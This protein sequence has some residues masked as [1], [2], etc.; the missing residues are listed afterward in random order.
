MSVVHPASNNSGA[1]SA[2]PSSPATLSSTGSQSA[3]P[4]PSAGFWDIGAYKA[5]VQRIRDGSEQLEELTKL[6]KERIDIENKYGKSLQAWYSKWH[7]YSERQVPSGFIKSSLDGI[8]SESK[9]LARVHLAV[10]ERFNDEIVKT[11]GLF[12]KDNYHRSAIRGF[13]EAKETEEEFE[14]AQRQWKKLYEK[15]ETSKKQYYCCC[16]AEK[17]AYIQMMNSHADTTLS[18]DGADKARD[19]HKKCREEVEKARATYEQHLREITHFNNVYMESMAFVFEK[20]QQME[21][22]RMK[23]VVEMLSGMQKVLVDLLSPPK[24]AQIHRI[25]EESFAM[26]GDAQLNIDLK[27]WSQ[28]HGTDVPP[29]FPAY[30][31]YTPEFR[32]ISN[33]G[34]QNS[35]GDGGVVLTKKIYRSEDDM[36]RPNSVHGDL[37]S[38]AARG[39]KRLAS[40][41]VVSQSTQDVHSAAMSMNTV[42]VP[43]AKSSEQLAHRR[44]SSCDSGQD[45]TTTNSDPISN[46]TSINGEQM[47]NQSA[48][49]SNPTSNSAAVRHQ[50]HVENEDPL[51]DPFPMPTPQRSAREVE[52]SNGIHSN[53]PRTTQ[54]LSSSANKRRAES[55]L[56]ENRVQDT[57]SNAMIKSIDSYSPSRHSHLHNKHH[58]NLHTSKA[59]SQASTPLKF[60]QNGQER[61]NNH[62]DE[63]YA[64]MQLNEPQNEAITKVSRVEAL[65]DY[66][67]IESDEIPLTKGEIIL[68]LSEPDSLGWCYGQKLD[69]RIVG[70]F[71]ASYVQ[72][73]SK[74]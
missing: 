67:P 56:K 1:Q 4:S 33:T 57:D 53:Q 60:E 14:K 44:G 28:L 5:N 68:S 17:S 40:S 59:S 19:R 3:T 55:V 45:N 37:N 30:E 51:A 49:V 48:A 13:K 36:H 66:Q 7:I 26:L 27:K 38:N 63:N 16:R 50:S 23:F 58:S 6:V 9:E 15:V 35:K 8:L 65:Y 62:R 25:L 32:N 70:W 61:I 18:Q 29:N 46:P 20:C 12:K 43:M 41:P 11:V 52:H 39:N 73:I 34:K 69:E 54:N 31:E 71:P 42:R 72:P 10:K 74:V 22:K 47:C 24:L 21:L 64:Y 2:G